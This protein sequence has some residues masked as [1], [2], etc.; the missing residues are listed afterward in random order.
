MQTK[1]DANGQVAPEDTFRRIITKPD[2]CSKCGFCLNACPV[3]REFLSESASPRGKIQLSRNI[4]EGKLDL[5]AYMKEIL[6]RCLMCGSCSATCPSGVQGAHLFSGM[7]WMAVRKLGIDWRK[8]LIYRVL[9]EKWMLST[10]THFAAW[11]KTHFGKLIN[12]SVSQ[13]LPVEGIPAFNKQPFTKTIKPI[14]PAIGPRHARVLYFHGCATNYLSDEIGHAVLHVLSHMGVEVC[15][16]KNQ[17][18]CGIPAISSGA[19][20]LALENVRAVVETFDCQDVDA[21]IVDCATCGSALRNEY[22]PLLKEMRAEGQDVD[23]TMIC[24]AKRMSAKVRDVMAYVAD[25]NDWLPEMTGAESISKFTYHDPCHLAKGQ[26]V[27]PQ[28][29]TLFRSLPNTDFVEMHEADACCGGG[30]VFQ[31]DHPEISASITAKK[32]ENIRHTGAAIL[33]TGC[34]GCRITIGAHLAG[35]SHIRVLH[36][37][38]LVDKALA[39]A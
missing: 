11:A 26:G 35:K 23:N 20:E 6:S 29:R 17:G 19:R 28:L 1:K 33:A 14:T 9:A 39:S 4:L 16:P 5:S 15:T 10:S 32:V 36:P 2:N 21:V 27:G 12:R 37:I 3:Y 22:V 31:I 24:A 13:R 8:K 7:R 25:H 30:G 34:P 38:I 18:C